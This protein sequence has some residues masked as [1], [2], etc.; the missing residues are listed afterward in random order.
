MRRQQNKAFKSWRNV[1]R[2][3]ETSLS[4]EIM[5]AG[6]KNGLVVPGVTYSGTRNY[7]LA[8]GMSTPMLSID[9]GGT[10]RHDADSSQV[11]VTEHFCRPKSLI[12]K[13]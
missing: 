12:E 7:F 4:P 6:T 10:V 2:G 11:G 3:P 8:P 9:R 5:Y 13:V 1:R